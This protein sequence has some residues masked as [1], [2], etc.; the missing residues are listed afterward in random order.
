MIQYATIR[1]L[2]KVYNKYAISEVYNSLTTR[3]DFTLTFDQ[4]TLVQTTEF[5]CDVLDFICESEYQ[6]NP[7]YEFNHDIFIECIQWFTRYHIDINQ[8]QYNIFLYG[9]RHRDPR[10]NLVDIAWSHPNTYLVKTVAQLLDK[11]KDYPQAQDL[12]N[13]MKICVQSSVNEFNIDLPGPEQSSRNIAEIYLETNR[14]TGVRTIAEWLVT[15]KQMYMFFFNTVEHL[16]T[17]RPDKVL[18]YLIK[19]WEHVQEYESDMFILGQVTKCVNAIYSSLHDN[20][21]C[22][23]ANM[24]MDYL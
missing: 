9:Y 3:N 23:L 18:R 22:D 11:Y 6:P 20:L 15:K 10:N 14:I 4:D 13:T 2:I 24:V 7:G 12:I 16:H 19:Y 1:D 8:H 17:S 5:V 21:I